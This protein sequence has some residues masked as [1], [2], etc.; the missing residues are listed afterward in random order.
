[1]ASVAEPRDPQRARYT[2]EILSGRHGPDVA[3]PKAD[4]NRRFISVLLAVSLPTL[5]AA[6]GSDEPSDPGASALA[7]S[8]VYRPVEHF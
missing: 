7:L 2:L 8:G 1:M 4:M 3:R 6:C 5:V